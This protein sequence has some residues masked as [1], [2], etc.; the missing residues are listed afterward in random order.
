MF[1]TENGQRQTGNRI[2]PKFVVHGFSHANKF[3][4][5]NF[6]SATAGMLF[7]PYTN[8]SFSGLTAL[9]F[10]YQT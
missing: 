8:T 2:A 1:H 6:N 10:G 9:V 5:V 4:S 3:V 7:N